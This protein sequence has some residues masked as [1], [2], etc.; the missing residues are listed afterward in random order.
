M[1]NLE[2]E[3]PVT[4][5]TYPSFRVAKLVEPGI[6]EVPKAGH[7]VAVPSNGELFTYSP[8]DRRD[9]WTGDCQCCVMALVCERPTGQTKPNTMMMHVDPSSVNSPTVFNEKLTELLYGITRSV[10]AVDTSVLIAGGYVGPKD[11]V[12][13]DFYRNYVREYQE[14][15]KLLNQAVQQTLG[16]EVV[17]LRRP[18][19]KYDAVSDVFYHSRRNRLVVVEPPQ[20]E[21]PDAPAVFKASQT[22]RVLLSY[23]KQGL[24]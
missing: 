16:V 8:F 7:P 18:K 21:L 12:P 17:I 6:I 2:S 1:A 14:M 23:K 13:T 4:V 10:E 11:F 3:I 24:L 22:P 15:I 9:K 5:S 20:P 19:A